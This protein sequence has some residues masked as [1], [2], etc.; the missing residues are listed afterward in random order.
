MKTG[1]AVILV[2]IECDRVIH[3]LSTLYLGDALRKAGYE[4]RVYNIFANEMDTSLEEILGLEPLFIGFS[5]L[6]GLQTKYSAIMSKKIKARAPGIPIVWG[7]VH[8]SLLP[9][10]CLRQD[11]IDIVA[12]GEGEELVVQLADAL[13]SGKPLGE[14]AGIGFK[15]PDGAV[16]INPLR[17]FLGDLDAY[18]PD[19]SLE[20]DLE[21][22]IVTL[23]DGRRQMDFTASRGC[24]F[25]CAF[26]YN[27]VF[28]QRRWRKYSFD[29]VIDEIR[30][31]KEDHNVRAIQ[32]HDDNFF[33]DLERAFAILD[34]L[35]KIDVI[36]T[37]CMIRL[38]LVT[39]DLLLRLSDLGTRR[40]FVGWES[41]SER[42]LSL[43]NKGLTRDFILEKFSVLA[44]FPEMA[45]TAA[46]IIGFPTETW[47]DVCQTIDLGVKLA[48][49]V[50]NIVVTYQTFIPYPGSHLYSLALA[51]GFSLPKDMSEYS[52]FDTFTGEMRLSWLP[53]ADSATP[54]LFYRIDKYGKLLTHSPGSSL[55]RTIGKNVFYELA[56][57]R[58]SRK[59]FA[60]PFEISVLHRFNRYYNPQCRV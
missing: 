2:K 38:E 35:K 5:V 48:S 54:E 31:L 45:V 50:P 24:P 11:C 14:V 42:I 15:G 59:C 51:S 34:A 57:F 39:E 6:T 37:S 53:W 21:R 7:G 17:P 22:S 43:I 8:P 10:D 23:A 12:R 32:F 29:Y 4:V 46:S 36:S 18:R 16:T 44:R 28:N 1:K 9:E 26:C 27:L 20:P 25:N 33:V 58:L 41:G 49:M 13:G 3:P 30:R 52:T 47:E 40:I 60:V 55:V 19:W 56:R